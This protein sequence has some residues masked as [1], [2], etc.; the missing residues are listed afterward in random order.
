MISIYPN[1]RAILILA[2]FI[3]LEVHFSECKYEAPILDEDIG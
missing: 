2:L 1:N 3:L